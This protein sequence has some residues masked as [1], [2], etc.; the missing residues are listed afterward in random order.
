MYPPYLAASMLQYWAWHRKNDSRGTENPHLEIFHQLLEQQED[1]LFQWGASSYGQAA[2]I[3]WISGYCCLGIDILA[4]RVSTNIDNIMSPLPQPFWTVFCIT[5]PWSTSKE[6][7]TGWKNAR[8]L[9]ARSSRLW[10][11]YL[12]RET[13]ENVTWLRRKTT[14]FG[15]RFLTISSWRWQPILSFFYLRQFQF[16]LF[17]CVR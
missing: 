4:K 11:H 7:H 12:N 3:L 13:L 2:E 1:M 14:K 6:S 9:C 16:F 5:A 15:L 10:T 8:N 17:D